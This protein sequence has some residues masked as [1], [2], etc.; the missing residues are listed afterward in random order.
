MQNESYLAPDSLYLQS[1]NALEVIKIENE[2]Y[3]KLK[4]DFQTYIMNSSA[5][6]NVPDSLRKYAEDFC[7]VL[8]KA[9]EA[10]ELDKVDH[11]AVQKAV[12]TIYADKVDI[13]E[14]L[15]G[16]T[17]LS[18]I[19]ETKNRIDEI[20]NRI[21]E[22]NSMSWIDGLWNSW[23]GS[24]SISSLESEKS[25]LEK[26]LDEFQN[27]E[28]R[29]DGIEN[30]TANLLN[31]S[32]ELRELIWAALETMEESFIDG[33]YRPE[34]TNNTGSLYQLKYSDLYSACHNIMDS[35]GKPLYSDEDIYWYIKYLE[36]QEGFNKDNIQEN[37]DGISQG[38][39]E[40][41]KLCNCGDAALYYA[42][43]MK[44][45]SI[46]GTNVFYEIQHGGS[47]KWGI[48]R[49]CNENSVCEAGCFCYAEAAVVS[50]IT[51]EPYTL[52]QL[53]IDS[54]AK[55]TYENGYFN[56]DNTNG[57]IRNMGRDLGQ[58]QGVLD[59]A[60]IAAE[61]KDVSD[62][63]VENIK[64]GLR[65]G[66]TYV[67][68]YYHPNKSGESLKGGHSVALVGLDENDNIIVACSNVGANRCS[69]ISSSF[70][71]LQSNYEG[72]DRIYEISV[73]DY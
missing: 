31:E 22:I 7:L 60:K 5:Q 73:S 1:Q 56:L 23:F 50:A 16:S 47:G 3:E 25:E 18:A 15:D 68:R 33:E 10:N 52:E 70:S 26:V 14:V 35:N 37:V 11:E 38:L 49:P 36:S 71:E 39:I 29:Y 51:G 72:V 21:E 41:S 55:V 6:G 30:D 27:K 28:H 9:M 32:E 34:T 8:D 24:D 65:D 13:H 44:Y 40:Y 20:N 59:N 17:I 63:S 54:G 67:L 46:N 66:K 45:V 2:K 42:S 58:L 43:D 61:V 53:F 12:E 57:L 4:E 69:I 19:E 64:D 62:Y 48:A